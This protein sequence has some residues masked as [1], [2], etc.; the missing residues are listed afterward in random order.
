[1]GRIIK[2]LLFAII[3]SVIM[4]FLSAPCF[5]QSWSGILSPSRAINW[6]NAGLPAG[7]TDKGGSNVETTTDPW[8]LPTRTQS[9]STISPSG[10]ASTDLSNINTALSGCADGH[11]VLLGSGTFLI[12]G[13][14]VMYQHSCSLRG[15]GPMSTTLS[16]TGAGT[17]FM[18]AGSSGGSCTLTSGSNFAA[19]S[20]TVSCNGLSGSA[21]AVSDIIQLTQCDTG[22]SGTPCSGTSADNGGLFVC[23]FQTTCMSEPAQSG[24]TSSQYQTFVVTSVSN[25]SGTYTIGLNSPLYMPNWSYTQAPVLTWNNPTY[26]GIGVG[27]E[28][29]TIYTTSS[30]ENFSIQANNLYASWIKGIRFVGVAV[31]TQ[32]DLATAEHCLIESNYAFSDIALDGNINAPIDLSGVSDSLIMNN[33]GTSGGSWEGF[34]NNAGNVLAYNYGR[35]TWTSYYEN[36]PSDHH[37][38]S[39]FDLWEGNEWGGITDD[40]TWGTHDLN[41][42]FRNYLTC[43][44]PPYVINP[45]TGV[46]RGLVIDPY[47]RFDNAVGN[48][49]GTLSECGTYQGTTTSTGIVFRIGTNVDPLAGTTLMRWGNVS[50]AEQ[51]S[52]TPSNSGIR[53]VS[54][55]VPTSLSGN[56]VPFQ[57]PVPSNNNLP[58]SFYFSGYSSSP[59]S[60]MTSGGTGF[61]WWKV[62]VSWTTFPTSCASTQLQPFPV[63]GPDQSGGSYVNGHG[64][65]VP[66]AIAWKNL[67]VDTNYQKSYTIASSSWSGG[68]ET[69]TFS[70]SVLPNTTHLMGPFQL[71]GVNSACTSGA[72]FN[73]NNEILMTGSTSTTITYALASN[74]GVQ[75]TGTFKFPDVRQFDERVYEADPSTTPLPPTNPQATPH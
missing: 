45:V 8:T 2:W 25:S 51:S 72:T 19:G 1:M 73:S 41:T 71:S 11:Y 54:S 49:I 68:T 70:S 36:L 10:V 42:F 37:A 32:M 34:G 12:Q 6:S 55:E 33:I 53:F 46:P 13:I 58:C 24:P 43:W 66:A 18:G 29:M 5:G 75:C 20:T 56:A 7:F 3:L 4:L 39:S 67:P 22:F 30:S 38:Y 65:D 21:P 52:D 44:D 27:V 23:G 48:T 61:S 74:P 64:Y 47:H 16:L 35:D 31:I 60:I 57:N 40:W 63:A 59:C 14:I 9:G 26:N 28:D 62:C 17:I 15:S 69:L 50:V